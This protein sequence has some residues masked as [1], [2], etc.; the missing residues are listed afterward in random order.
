MSWC[1]YRPSDD[2]AQFGYAIPA[3]MYAAG[4]LERAL[5]LNRAVWHSEAFEAK[6]SKLL[7]GIQEGRCRLS[8]C[9]AKE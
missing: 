4:A 6:A 2:P 7:K 5:A 9:P 3:N 1:G 8:F